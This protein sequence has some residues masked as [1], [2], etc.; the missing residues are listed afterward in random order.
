MH[1]I[2]HFFQV[3]VPAGSPWYLTLIATLVPLVSGLLAKFLADGLKQIIPAYDNSSSTV[4]LVVSFLIGALV[5]FV[6]THLAL[7]SPLGTDI[8]GWGADVI[9]AVLTALAQSGIYRLQ[10]NNQVAAQGMATREQMANKINP[11]A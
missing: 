8:H 4:K 10:K 2:L 9:G 5:G 7:A 1:A 6:N 11:K 3:V